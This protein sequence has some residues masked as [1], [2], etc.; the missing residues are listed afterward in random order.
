[1]TFEKKFFLHFDFGW[2]W[3]FVVD[4]WTP[5]DVGAFVDKPVAVLDVVETFVCFD[6]TLYHGFDCLT[7][8]LSVLETFLESFLSGIGTAFS[9]SGRDFTNLSVRI[10]FGSGFAGTLSNCLMVF[11]VG[12]LALGLYTRFA[13][14]SRSILNV[15]C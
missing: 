7:C 5:F 10:T 14:T 9:G 15:L 4:S 6:S 1:M 13:G 12:T 3:L 11:R 2:C 8:L